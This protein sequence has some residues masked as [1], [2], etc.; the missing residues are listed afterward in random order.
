MSGFFIF[1]KEIYISKKNELYAK[2]YKILL[3][4]IYFS[5]EKIKISDVD[6]DF[7][8]RAKGKSKMSIKI[9]LFLIIII[10]KKFILRIK[11]ALY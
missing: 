2:G 9:I 5:K 10:I 7:K 6:I 11:M 3:D 8:S 1:K 4:L